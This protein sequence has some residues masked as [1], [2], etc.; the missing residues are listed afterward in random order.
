M[1][2]RITVTD[3]LGNAHQ[4]IIT[5]NHEDSKV[6]VSRVE[7]ESLFD[8]RYHNARWN[9]WSW[10]DRRSKEILTQGEIK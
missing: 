4:E 6:T 7:L 9:I 3:G 10:F 2:N 8:R 5:A 1:E